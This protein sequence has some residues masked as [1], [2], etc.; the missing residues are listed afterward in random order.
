MRPADALLMV[1][2]AQPMRVIG[3][4]GSTAH[5]RDDWVAEEVPL[6]LEY[7]G[8]AY[9]VMLASPLDLHDFALG[10]SLTEGLLDSPSELYGVDEV[11]GDIGLTLQLRVA[12]AASVRLRERRRAMAGRTGCGLCGVDSLSQVMRTLPA[13]LPGAPVVPQA[14]CRGMSELTT[15]QTLHHATG[16][17]HAAAWC[18]A[19]GQVQ[20]L[21]E[22][23]GRHNALD[24]LVGALARA[25]VSDAERRAGFVAITSR[26][27][28][29]MVQKTASA[30]MSM[31]AAVSAPTA[32]A[33]RLAQSSG[34]TL[35]G[36]ARGQNMAVYADAGRLV[37]AMST[38][39]P[40]RDMT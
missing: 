17:V 15:L 35:L 16:A 21:R 32:L 12:T 34:L 9:A 4:H 1:D 36:F 22:D 14:I 29:E 6:A 19:D 27:S 28:F 23:V 31:L 25:R 40:T 18:A 11:W 7:N 20:V 2:G 26:A 38:V 39:F 13:L 33:V 37:A 10:F 30:G 5:A 24:K 3:L 8:I